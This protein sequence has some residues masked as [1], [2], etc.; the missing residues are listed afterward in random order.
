MENFG[1]DIVTVL[2]GVG[3][4]IVILI[5]GYGVFSVL[6][7]FN[8]TAEIRKGN[9]AAGMY[10]GSKLLGLAIIVSMVS[11]SSTDWVNMLIWSGVGMVLLCVLYVL[12]DFL[13]PKLDVCAEIAK[14][15]MAVAQLLRA[16]IVGVSVV[17]GTF[18]L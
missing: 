2:I 14:G 1:Q 11:Y 16:V 3:L 8:D 10:M 7:R 12:F 13:L 6:T 18:L 17:I 9:A 5:L 15:N 4:L